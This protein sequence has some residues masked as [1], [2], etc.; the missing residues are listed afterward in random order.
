MLGIELVVRGRRFP[1]VFI[2]SSSAL[3]ARCTI[4]AYVHLYRPEVALNLHSVLAH[5][6]TPRSRRWSVCVD[7]WHCGYVCVD[8]HR[9][10]QEH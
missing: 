10:L 4:R 5:G 8:Q 7:L 6:H 3:L 9:M 2:V 1:K